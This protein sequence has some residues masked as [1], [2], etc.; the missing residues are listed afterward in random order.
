L[1]DAHIFARSD[2]LKAEFIRV[3][4]LVQQVYEDFGIHDYY[5]R[6]SYRD[7]EDKAKYI[8]NDEMWEKA[9]AMLKETMEEMNVEYV[10][11]IGEA[12]FYGPKLDV[13]VQTAIGK[14]E[15]LSTVQIDYQLPERFDLTYIGQDG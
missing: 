15:T 8:D 13:Q 6:L 9:Q 12:A 4:E 7:P 5:F 14:D 1:N 2:Q 10:E 11:A 3:V